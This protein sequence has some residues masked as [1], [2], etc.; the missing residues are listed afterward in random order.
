MSGIC[1]YFLECW[2]PSVTTTCNSGYHES[3]SINSFDSAQDVN[4][5]VT[6]EGEHS[7]YSRIF[8]ALH[9]PERAENT[10]R[11]AVGKMK[12]FIQTILPGWRTPRTNREITAD[13]NRL[14]LSLRQ[15]YSD[16]QQAKSELEQAQ[17]ELQRANNEVRQ[18][19]DSAHHCQ[20]ELQASQSENLRLQSK[21]RSMRDFL[22]ENSHNQIVSD[23]DVCE[24][25]T[26][27]RQRIQRLAS[28]KAY[29]IEEYE[30]LTLNESWFEPR[31]I[32]ALWGIS[33]KPGRLAIL[34]GL[35]FQFLYNSILS[36]LLFD[37]SD[38][39]ASPCLTGL[40]SPA[41]SLSQTFGFFERII[42]DCGG[43]RSRPR[44]F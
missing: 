14:A 16:L 19:K 11:T 4:E 10:E 28:N 24:R 38:A 30:S 12:S 20:T 22:I 37:V 7:S 5:A 36:R 32:E 15:T 25:F 40:H 26:Q 34:R 1:H 39:K 43:K 18:L 44:S 41:P 31:Y 17:S 13:Y 21:E 27:L 9:R 35:M 8:Q 42:N 33:L 3:N 23:R 29:N 6:L 2:K